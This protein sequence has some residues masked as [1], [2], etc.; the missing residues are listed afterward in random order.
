MKIAAAII[1]TA[2]LTGCRS[3][4]VAE[5]PDRK[6]IVGVWECVDFPSGFLEKSGFTDTTTSRIVIHENGICS[7]YN[8]PL[9]SPYRFVELESISWTL[10]QPSMTPSGA[11]SV[12]LAGNFLQCRRNGDELEL[13]YLISGMDEYRVIYQKAEQVVVE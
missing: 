9:R 8:F 1:F 12:E 7:A 3:K 6:D 11:W 2:I 4:P 10:T 13:S 5:M